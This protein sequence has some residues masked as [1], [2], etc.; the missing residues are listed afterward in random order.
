MPQNDRLS[1]DDRLPPDDMGGD[2]SGDMG[3][4]RDTDMAVQYLACIWPAPDKYLGKYLT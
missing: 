2:I 3:G 4:G 1:P